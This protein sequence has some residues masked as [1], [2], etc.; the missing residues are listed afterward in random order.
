MNGER[1]V[2]DACLP[3]NLWLAPSYC[4]GTFYKTAFLTLG[5]LATLPFPWV[6]RLVLEA[7][8]SVRMSWVRKEPSFGRPTSD[9]RKLKEGRRESTKKPEQLRRPFA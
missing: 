9:Q 3:L 5:T 1:R 7:H 8:T 4:M 6:S 2:E